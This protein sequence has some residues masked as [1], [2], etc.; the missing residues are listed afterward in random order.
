M[1]ARSAPDSNSDCSRLFC[2]FFGFVLLLSPRW[3]EEDPLHILQTVEHCIA[4]VWEKLKAMHVDPHDVVAIGVTNQRESTVVWDKNT[5]MP[6]C[7]AIREYWVISRNAGARA[8]LIAAGINRMV[9]VVSWSLPSAFREGIRSCLVTD[10]P[11]EI[12]PLLSLIQMHHCWC[13]NSRLVRIRCGCTSA[14]RRKR[15]NNH[16]ITF[17]HNFTFV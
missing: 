4:Q 10:R 5:G 17:L 1:I 9:V 14:I 7:N 2:F 3:V 6:Y 13:R 11:L 16:S 8:R 15:E 12:L